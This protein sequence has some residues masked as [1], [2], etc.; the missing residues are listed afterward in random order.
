M[1]A[2]EANKAIERA[3][4][5]DL[6]RYAMYLRKSRVDL[7]LEAISKEET[8]ARH[9]KMLFA[10]AERNGILPSQITIYHEI[11]SGDSIDERPE[12]LRLLDDVYK[13]TYAGVLVAEIERLARGN[14]KDQGEV[15]DAFTFSDT[16]ILTPQRIYDP[17]DEF[18][19][20]YFEFGL[21]M[22]RREYKTIRRRLTTGKEQA[23]QE[24]NY[25][26]P[27]PPFGFDIVKKNRKN[28][29]LVEKPE[30]SKYVKMIFDWYTEDGKPTSWIARQLTLM[31]VPTRKNGKDWSRT[32]IKDIL[33]NEHYIG[34]IPWRKLQTVKEKDPTT[35]R[36]VKKRK[37]NDTPK[38]YN[39]KHDGFISEEQF[40]KV[41][42]IYGSQAPVKTNNELVNPLAGLLVCKRCGKAIN[43]QPYPDNRRPRY[44]HARGVHACKMK[45]IFVD[46]V[47]AAVV[48]ALEAHIEDFNIEI[49]TGS[50]NT[51]AERQM[52][53]V[54]DMEKELAKQ[55]RMKKRLFES[56][57]ADDGTYTREEFIERKGM[58]N[59]TIE[60]LKR[61]IETMR[62]ATPAPVDYEE[63]IVTYRT[64]IE[65]L[66]N[67]DI[68]VKTKNASL[69][70]FIDRI[71]FDTV[72]LGRNKGAE[73]VLD[74]HFKQGQ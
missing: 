7:E 52:Q 34:L 71:E 23:A 9:K 42:E 51:V 11:V 45:S 54:S 53:A 57:E 14:T 65:L 4:A 31:G 37:R 61:E 17:N 12:M 13:G 22:S 40:W 56:W 26:L 39:G 21:F 72:D 8:L 32:T 55:E 27:Y 18:D 59:A 25:L 70:N 46:D 38:L 35:G 33:F 29:Y 47:I 48:G 41:R 69:K 64:A 66:C 16:K 30:D 5:P 15:A 10:L 3:K 19:Q 60:N 24:G 44:H 74:M 62:K 6:K 20:E 2:F 63:L 50:T 49:E 1:T 43:Y 36:V 28:R 68:D 58:Y 67:S 73:P